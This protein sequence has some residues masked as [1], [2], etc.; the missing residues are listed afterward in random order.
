MQWLALNCSEGGTAISIW[1]AATHGHFEMVKLVTLQCEIYCVA[2]TLQ[3]IVSYQA[4]FDMIEW[5]LKHYHDVNHV[6]D[7]YSQKEGL[8]RNYGPM[9]GI[10]WLFPQCSVVFSTVTAQYSKHNSMHLHE[11]I[12][13]PLSR[14]WMLRFYDGSLSQS[15]CTLSKSGIDCTA[16]SCVSLAC[17]RPT[18]YALGHDPVPIC[19]SIDRGYEEFY[20]M[21]FRCQNQMVSLVKCIY[22]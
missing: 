13:P 4:R 7:G 17:I 22:H 2:S 20:G 5:L 1:R 11:A 6:V 12:S 10:T 9:N 21:V 15:S 18:I 3:L 8:E 19:A 16:Y 14:P